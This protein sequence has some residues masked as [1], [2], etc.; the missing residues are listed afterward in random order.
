MLDVSRI[1]CVAASTSFL[2][3]PATP[4]VPQDHGRKDVDQSV[5]VG[6][7]DTPM[8]PGQPWRV[9]D[10]NRPVPPVVTPGTG[11]FTIDAWVIYTAVGD[12]RQLDI[13]SKRNASG[14]AYGYRLF[15]RDEF[16]TT[17]IL[18]LEV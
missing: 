12:G 14:I 16:P 11:D 2:S 1:F 17:G 15:I 6:Y 4:N 9:H 8:L 10:K 5:P 7:D 18:T 3:L 13:V